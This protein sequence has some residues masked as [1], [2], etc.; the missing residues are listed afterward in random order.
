VNGD[1]RDRLIK[2]EATM[3]ERWDNHDKRSDEIWKRIEGNIKGIFGKLD[4]L[5]C[6]THAEKFNG[7]SKQIAYLWTLLVLML[8]SCVGGFWWLLKVKG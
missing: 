6:Q 5:K 3:K 8:S 2:L 1:E 7:H 4:V